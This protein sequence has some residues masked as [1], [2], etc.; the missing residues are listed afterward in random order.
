MLY[1]DM[2]TYGFQ[3]D[4]YRKAREQGVIFSAMNWKIIRRSGR[5]RQVS[6]TFTDPILGAK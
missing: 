2:R 4:Y 3:E 1:R 5:R 6:V